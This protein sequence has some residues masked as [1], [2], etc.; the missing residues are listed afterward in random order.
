MWGIFDLHYQMTL[1]SLMNAISRVCLFAFN[2]QLLDFA[3]PFNIHNQ[4]AQYILV[5]VD[6]CTRYV[7]LFSAGRISAWHVVKSVEQ[8]R[9]TFGTIGTIVT[10]LPASA[11]QFSLNT[12]RPLVP[13]RYEHQLGTPRR[14]G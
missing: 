1:E 11:A 3:G 10:M 2:H 8:I 12:S 6:Y 14:M 4:Q 7:F 5:A 9:R 13:L